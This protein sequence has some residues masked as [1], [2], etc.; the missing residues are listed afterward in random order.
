[1]DAHTRSPSTKRARRPYARAGR[2]LREL[3]ETRGLTQRELARMVV[4]EYYTI[5][6]QLENGWGRV[7]ADRYPV[8]AD[9]LG[10]EPREF[11]R[12][13]TFH[14]DHDVVPAATAAAAQGNDVREAAQ[15]R[16]S[17]QDRGCPPETD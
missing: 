7:P 14:Y 10:V 9:A 12:K 11:A 16:R 1:M 15:P 5:I 6:S 8:W 2:W 17:P 3:R 13:L 4:A